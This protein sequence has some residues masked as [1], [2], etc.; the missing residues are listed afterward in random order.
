VPAITFS[1]NAMPHVKTFIA[2][3][4]TA[5]ALTGAPVAYA[6]YYVTYTEPQRVYVYDGYVY[7][8]APRY[9][10][11]EPYPN[12]SRR[13]YMDEAGRRWDAMTN[14]GRELSP[15]DQ[16]RIYGRPRD[17]NTTYY[18]WNDGRWTYWGAGRAGVTQDS[19]PN[20]YATG[21]YNPKH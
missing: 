3:G 18:V 4:M 20:D 17:P 16:D 8:P 9:Y 15:Y 11:Y 2:A 5:A 14:Y 7:E 10:V 19:N 1:E 13:W 6:D 21:I 12:W